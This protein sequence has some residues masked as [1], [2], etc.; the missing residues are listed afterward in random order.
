[1]KTLPNLPD[2]VYADAVY[3]SCER[4]RYL[5]AKSTN[6]KRTMR[7]EHTCL[8]IMLNP[9]T[10]TADRDDPTVRKCQE[11]SR[12]NG[13]ATTLITNLFAIRSTDPSVLVKHTADGWPDG[14]QDNARHLEESI[15]AYPNII[16]A[17]GSFKHPEMLTLARRIQNL[18]GKYKRK[19]KCLGVNK[20]GMPKHP[21]YVSYKAALR[22]WRMMP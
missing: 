8:W 11:F 4:Y 19:L 18:A 10:A 5:L 16:V 21:L 7:P 9:S 22:D 17:W 3:S 6:E 15:Q 14:E 20:D 2:V 12:R 13:F 1:M